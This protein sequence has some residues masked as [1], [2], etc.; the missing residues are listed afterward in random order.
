MAKHF[1]ITESSELEELISKTVKKS[2][3]DLTQ[4]NEEQAVYAS[5]KEAA[6]MLGISLPTL[7]KYTKTGVV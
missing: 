7:N 2:I 1:F 3:Q 6:D 5:R 4:G